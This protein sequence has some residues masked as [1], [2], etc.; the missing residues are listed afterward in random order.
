VEPRGG[1]LQRPL[2]AHADLL[3]GA[4]RPGVR[5]RYTP[6]DHRNTFAWITRYRHHV[7][8]RN[9]TFQADYRF[10]RD[11]WGIRAHTVEVAWSQVVGGAWT[12]RPALRY[13]TQSQADFYTPLIPQPQPAILSSDQRLAAFGGLTPSLR[14]E[15]RHPAAGASRAPSATSRTRAASMRAAAGASSSRPCARTMRSSV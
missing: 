3:S 14:V 5:R 4:Q 7:A 10:Y 12:L 8:S 6:A 9:G 1:L 11:D 2:P 15:Y 13:Y